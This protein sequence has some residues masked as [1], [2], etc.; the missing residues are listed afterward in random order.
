MTL[1]RLALL[2]L[3]TAALLVACGGS[4]EGTQTP[5]DPSK[6]PT[7]S[8]PAPA[9]SG[10]DCADCGECGIA[11]PVLTDRITFPEIGT[12]AAGE[13]VVGLLFQKA[14]QCQ[15]QGG[16]AYVLTYADKSATL[17]PRA[18]GTKITTST[19]T[20]GNNEEYVWNDRDLRARLTRL[21]ADP[22]LTI[23]FT[24]ASGSVTVLCNIEGGQVV[25]I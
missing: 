15:G 7:P 2:A 11:G 25:C 23:T 3:S 24:E 17:A 12:S 6:G 9:P 21:T 22:R 19:A 5:G 13:A 14:G 16:I 4:T 8:S 18:A 1:G 20:Y 10:S